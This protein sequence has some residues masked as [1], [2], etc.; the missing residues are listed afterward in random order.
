MSARVTAIVLNWCKEADT[1]A[2]LESLGASR[3]GALDV[4]LVDNG[5]RD[6]SGDRLHQRFP[7]VEYLQ[8]GTN[9]GYSGGNNRGIEHALD[10]GA[11]YL[12][13]L[14]NDTQVLPGTLQSALRTIR[15][16]DDI[17][18]VG[19]RPVTGI[20]KGFYCTATARRKPSATRIRHQGHL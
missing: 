5:S 15:S 7:S 18:A 10:A 3:Y 12:L 9:L 17:G 6:G 14:N 19:A 11:E 16:A 13:I 4:L 2:C 20:G 1:A 8:T